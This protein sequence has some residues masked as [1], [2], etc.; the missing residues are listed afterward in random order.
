MSLGD[1]FRSL[2]A[3]FKSI[4]GASWGTPE[5]IERRVDERMA[6]INAQSLYAQPCISWYGHRFVYANQHITCITCGATTPTRHLRTSVRPCTAWNGHLY[7]LL[8]ANAVQ[9]DLRFKYCVICG[10]TYALEK[11]PCK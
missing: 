4:F 9:S 3:G 7:K 2:G 1:G 6:R 11:S 8:P 5:D 10:S